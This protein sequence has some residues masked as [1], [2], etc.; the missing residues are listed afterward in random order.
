MLE[1]IVAQKGTCVCMYMCAYVHTLYDKDVHVHVYG[2]ESHQKL[3]H[4]TCIHTVVIQ[5][6]VAGILYTIH[7]H[8]PIV[9][10]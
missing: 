4:C 9:Q 7:V 6:M 8:I 1:E 2:F 3:L 5:Y 10:V